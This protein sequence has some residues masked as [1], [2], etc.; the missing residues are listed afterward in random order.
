MFLRFVELYIHVFVGVGR[1]KSGKAL[2]GREVKECV[3]AYC[4]FD[5]V[6]RRIR[7]V[8]QRGMY[9]EDF[10]EKFPMIDAGLLDEIILDRGRRKGWK[11]RASDIARRLAAQHVGTTQSNVKQILKQEK[12]YLARTRELVAEV[13]KPEKILAREER[14]PLLWPEEPRRLAQEKGEDM[15]ESLFISLTPSD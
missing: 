13:P 6:V 4:V 2:S 11:S 9:H 8:W 10:V 7:D 12:K 1:S 14:V 15:I 3:I 5:R